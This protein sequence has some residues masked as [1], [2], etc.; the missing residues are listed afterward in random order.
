MRQVWTDDEL[1]RAL[2]GLYAELEPQ[3]RGLGAMRES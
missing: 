2:D 3:Q 1:D